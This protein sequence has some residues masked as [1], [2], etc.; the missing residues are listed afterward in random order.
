VDF[1]DFAPRVL[2]TEQQELDDEV[3]PYGRSQHY[4][5]SNRVASSATQSVCQQTAGKVK[6]VNNSHHRSLK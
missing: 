2:L 1:A 5:A 6:M 4:T 3:G